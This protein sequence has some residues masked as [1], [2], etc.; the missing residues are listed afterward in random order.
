M[1][2]LFYMRRQNIVIVGVRATHED[3]QLARGRYRVKLT[4][5]TQPYYFLGN[6]GAYRHLT[7]LRRRRL[8]QNVF[9]IYFEI[10]HLFGTIQRDCR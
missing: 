3:S 9:P 8:V 2:A 1:E 7:H 6:C 5:D 4:R 10:S